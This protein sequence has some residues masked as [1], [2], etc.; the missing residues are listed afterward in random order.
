MRRT[1]IEESD[2]EKLILAGAG[3]RLEPDGNRP[4]LF[5]KMRSFFRTGRNDTTPNLKQF[6]HT[7]LLRFEYRMLGFLTACHPITLVRR[8]KHTNTIKISD[9][10]HYLGRTIS[11]YGWCVTAKTVMTKFG[12][13]MQFVTFEDETGICETVLFPEAYSKFIR[14]LMI[15]EAFSITGKVMEEFGAVT[16]EVRKVEPL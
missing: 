4:K 11:F 2:A 12:D 10:P 8:N 16:V 5:W 7:E 6:S 15:K 9:I 3:D 13:P 14:F 1:G